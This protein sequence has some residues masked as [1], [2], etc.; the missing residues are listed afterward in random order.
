MRYL[1]V[2]VACT[3]SP[4]YF[5]CA[6]PIKAF[7][8]SGAAK[9]LPEMSSGEGVSPGVH[10]PHIVALVCEDE[11]QALIWLVHDPAGAAEADPVDKKHRGTA[12]GA[13]SYPS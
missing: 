6:Q 7:K 13:S 11:P 12:R 3:S 5:I 1:S 2:E 4:S 8:M 10:H 9:S